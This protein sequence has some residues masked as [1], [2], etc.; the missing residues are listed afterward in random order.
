MGSGC[1]GLVGD[2]ELLQGMAV[3]VAP[4]GNPGALLCTVQEEQLVGEVKV[5][6]NATTSSWQLP[7][8]RDP[9]VGFTPPPPVSAAPC[10]VPMLRARRCCCPLMLWPRDMQVIKLLLHLQGVSPGCGTSEELRSHASHAPGTH[11]CVHTPMPA[12]IRASRCSP[13][14]ASESPTTLKPQP[15]RSICPQEIEG[16]HGGACF[17]WRQKALKAAR[18]ALAARVNLADR[19][20]LAAGLRRGGGRGILVPAGSLRCVETIG[21][22]WSYLAC[23]IGH[24]GLH[25]AA[26]NRILVPAGSLRC[27]EAV[28]H[29]HLIAHSLRRFRLMRCNLSSMP[30]HSFVVET[31]S[32]N[33]KPFLSSLSVSSG[34][35]TW[36][37]HLPTWSR[38]AAGPSFLPA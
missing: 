34:T 11:T 7:P 13:S 15:R 23:R 10:F 28:Q 8:K 12:S 21:C 26:I 9:C 2:W 5:E 32:I 29:T 1:H 30:Q 14:C 20:A 38:C 27:I 37:T 19:A 3:G 6:Y 22:T 25:L 33:W 16:D 31:V 17:V 36:Q 35:G 4:A 24:F 18:T